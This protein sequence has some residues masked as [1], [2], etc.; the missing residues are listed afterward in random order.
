MR[1][2]AN[3][4]PA[5]VAV[6]LALAGYLQPLVAA[7]PRAAEIFLALY[8]ISEAL[9]GLSFIRANSTAELAFDSLVKILGALVGRKKQQ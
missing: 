2:L 3:L 1:K 7:H 5:V 9:A 4:L 6:I 8:V